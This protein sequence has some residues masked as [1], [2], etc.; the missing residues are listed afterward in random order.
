MS[1]KTILRE[2]ANKMSFLV[3][4]DE[5]ILVAKKQINDL[6]WLVDK[7]FNGFKIEYTIKESV[8][9]F[10]YNVTGYATLEGYMQNNA[11]SYGDLIDMIHDIS[12][13]FSNC[14][15]NG[16][17]EKNFP[18]NLGYIFVNRSTQN[19]K[20]IYLPFFFLNEFKVMPFKKLMEILLINNRYIAEKDLHLEAKIRDI[21]SNSNE[22]DAVN[23]LLQLK[24]TIH[25]SSRSNKQYSRKNNNN[26][27]ETGDKTEF[28]NLDSDKTE[29]L[30]G[31]F[32]ESSKAIKVEIIHPKK[33][34]Y[35]VL[36]EEFPITL[37]R[38]SSNEVYKIDESSV[39]RKHITLDVLDDE[40]IVKDAG[41]S[42][43]VKVNSKL[44]ESN[45]NHT[46]SVGDEIM[47]GRVKI[48]VLE[49]FE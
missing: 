38:E 6:N 1:L 17:Y 39:S 29:F 4:V 37:G 43:G 21:I 42:N 15:E 40:I 3:G 27:G 46:L 12:N 34:S 11:C 2:D 5:N 32:D 20:L 22:L 24:S 36:F 26:F 18:I 45:R 7:G 9:V 14:D 31:G 48:K 41:S 19:V 10:Q 8:N 44:I 16:I 13:I 23:S 28:L 47:I 49:I 30:F 35:E 33:D 25:K